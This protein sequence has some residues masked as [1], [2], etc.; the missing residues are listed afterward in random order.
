MRAARLIGADPA[1]WPDLVQSAEAKID[2]GLLWPF[3]LVLVDRYNQELFDPQMQLLGEPE[4][5]LTR[6]SQFIHWR[7]WPALTGD[8]E[9]VRNVLRA[10]RALPSRDRQRAAEALVGY[11]QE[12]PF[13]DRARVVDPGNEE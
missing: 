11:A 4:P 5:Q 3:W 10:T 13:A 8:D 6:F 2:L 12:M 9:C 1:Q 7:V